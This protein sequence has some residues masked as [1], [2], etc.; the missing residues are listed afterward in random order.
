M[1]DYATAFDTLASS[2]LW[3]EAAAVFGGFMAPTVVRN[4]ASGVVPDAV[5]EPELYGL[6]TV[7]GGQFLPAYQHEVTLGGG[8][9]TV[10]K[11]AERFGLKSTV[12]GVGN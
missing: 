8:I 6:A 11:A 1:A 9:Y 3:V 4:L 10:D 2:D 5:D 12:Q 7:A